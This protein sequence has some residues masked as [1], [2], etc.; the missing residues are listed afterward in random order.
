M[1]SRSTLAQ[2]HVR[3]RVAKGLA[4][5]IRYLHTSTPCYNGTQ[6]IPPDKNLE[7]M[8]HGAQ[9]SLS[10]SSSTT[11]PSKADAPKRLVQ[12]NK[13]QTRLQQ[14]FAKHPA[15]FDAVY[16]T[17]KFLR[18]VTPKYMSQHRVFNIYDLLIATR[19]DEE[20]DFWRTCELHR[21]NA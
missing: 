18:I 16:K 10:A 1:L 3:V 2:R 20:A 8:T 19:A 14:Y 9:S 11:T 12:R 6:P 4:Y 13:K 5:R 17:A 21:I 7:G 15:V